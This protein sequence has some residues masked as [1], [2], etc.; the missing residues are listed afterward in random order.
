M[1]SD[2]VSRWRTLALQRSI[3]GMGLTVQSLVRNFN[4]YLG[5]GAL[6]G[7]SHLYHLTTT[8][9][10][11]PL[12]TGHHEGA[13]Y[14]ATSGRRTGTSAAA[15]APGTAP[16]A[17]RLDDSGGAQGRRLPPLRR[18][19]VRSSQPRPTGAD[20]PVRPEQLDAILTEGG[21]GNP[22]RASARIASWFSR[23]GLR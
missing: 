18:H 12:V 9:E 8:T 22:R 19:H 17:P 11:R 4:E 15:G 3:V 20:V 23:N 7:T 16:V 13:L 21:R 1:P 14:T 6:G 5:A 10:L 2:L